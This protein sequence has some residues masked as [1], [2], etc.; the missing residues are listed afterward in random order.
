MRIVL[1]TVAVVLLH[2][3]GYAQP[4]PEWSVYERASPCPDT[5]LDWMA[6]AKEHPTGAN[7]W[8]EAVGARRTAD[9]ADAFEQSDTLRA[10]DRFTGVCCRD[11]SVWKDSATG[12]LSIMKGSGSAGM[13]WMLEKSGLC[14]EQ[15][16]EQAGLAGMCGGR[17]MASRSRHL[18]CFKDP[19]NPFDLDGHLERSRANTPERCI[20]ICRE[21]G[22]KYAGLQYSESCLCGNTY[23]K[24]GRTDNCNMKCTGDRK[25]TCGGYNAN[26]VYFAK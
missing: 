7:A 20:K 11:W 5:R 16:A 12:R 6:V 22:F 24:S 9:F 8:T 15:A 18:G 23:G 17:R 19:Q 26:D 2:S 10:G 21:K 3:A 1:L 13:G 25:Q 4:N 14:C